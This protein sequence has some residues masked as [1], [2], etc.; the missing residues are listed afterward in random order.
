MK[1]AK[2]AA[3]ACLPEQAMP[4]A[5]PTRFDSAMPTLKKRSGYF[6]AKYSV[7]VELCTS[8]SRTT[9]SRRSPPS[10]ASA[11]PKA[12]RVALPILNAMAGASSRKS[13]HGRDHF[14]RLLRLVRLQGDAVVVGVVD[15]VADRVALRG[16]G[17]DRAGPALRLGG[18]VEGVQ[19]FLQALAVDVLRE[20]AERLPA[21]RDRV[22]VQHLGRRAGLLVAVVIDD[23]HQVVQ[24]KL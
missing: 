12:S 8:P 3:H 22:Q 20:P 14:Q 23:G 18:L 2:L 4:A 21:R 11:S 1:Q 10:L 17:D 6:S 7:R 19:H 24:L 9:M 16:A 5:T 15:H 13:G